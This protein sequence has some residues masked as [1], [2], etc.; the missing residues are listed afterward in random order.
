MVQLAGKKE[1]SNEKLKDLQKL[2]AASSTII[3][4]LLSPGSAASVAPPD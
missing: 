4:T 3:E 2:F 1:L